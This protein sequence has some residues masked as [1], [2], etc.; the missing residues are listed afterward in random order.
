M[1]GQSVVSPLLRNPTPHSAPHR[2]LN[3]HCGKV[4]GLPTSFDGTSNSPMGKRRE[5]CRQV[6]PSRQGDMYKL[7][8]ADWDKRPPKLL[9]TRP[10]PVWP[11]R[12]RQ[13]RYIRYITICEHGRLAELC[14][15]SARFSTHSYHET[16]WQWKPPLEKDPEALVVFFVRWTSADEHARSIRR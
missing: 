9:R 16:T 11:M 1:L 12:P 15:C 13:T 3:H 2:T 5:R 6:L 8:Q 7:R 14:S 10:G 4:V